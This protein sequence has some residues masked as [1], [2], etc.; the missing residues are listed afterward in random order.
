MSAFSPLGT[1]G[2]NVETV[3]FKPSPLTTPDLSDPKMANNIYIARLALPVSS[4]S[5]S[6]QAALSGPI[7]TP[8]SIQTL[9]QQTQPIKPVATDAGTAQAEADRYAELLGHWLM[10][11]QAQSLQPVLVQGQVAVAA[12]LREKNNLNPQALQFLGQQM[13]GYLFQEG[14]PGLRVIPEPTYFATQ[15]HLHGQPVD[16]AFTD[17]LRQTLNDHGPTILKLLGKQAAG[18]AGCTR[19]GSHELVRLY[20]AWKAF[21]GAYPNAYAQ[22]L[23]DP[24]LPLLSTIQDQLLYSHSACDGPESVEDELQSFLAGYPGSDLKPQLKK[25]LGS[26]RKKSEGMQFYQGVTPGCRYF[27]QVR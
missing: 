14:P 11:E 8:A 23:T 27:K 13:Q 19:F 25:R 5:P 7:P 18:M 17:L 6:Q 12:I 20:G 26:F 3:A 10:A 2:K 24:N 16:V 22:L 4:P 1:S 15:A 21:Q 9:H